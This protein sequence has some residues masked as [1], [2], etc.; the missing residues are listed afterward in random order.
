MGG[1]LS[2]NFISFNP[3]SPKTRFCSPTSRSRTISPL[4]T[5]TNHLTHHHTPSLLPLQPQFYL[6]QFFYG[7]F[8]CPWYAYGQTMIAEVTPKGS[9]FLFFSLFSIIGKTSAFIGPF[10][11]QAIA[12]DSGNASS[13]FYFLLALSLASCVLLWPL[14]V[15]KSKIEQARFIEYDARD[16]KLK[17][18]DVVT[19]AEV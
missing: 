19:P 3:L 11:T 10:V 1:K 9:E 15:K 16:K 17:K 8:A 4:V 14:D 6:F 18:G 7:W 2:S 12:D 13:P 5:H